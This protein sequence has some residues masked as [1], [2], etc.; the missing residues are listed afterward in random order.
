MYRYRRLVLIDRLIPFLAA[1]VGFVAL[2]AVMATQL[3]AAGRSA[4]FDAEVAATREA[5]A[6]ATAGLAAP[7]AQPAAEQGG[8]TT[9]VAALDERVARLE[10]DLADARAQ[11]ETA[12][13][14]VPAA[15]GRAL[16]AD[17]AVATDS[18]DAFDDTTPPATD[19]A[20]M[21]PASVDPS[22]PTTDCIPLGTR[23]MATPNDSYPICQSKTVIKVGTISS[24]MVD[25]AGA[26]PIPATGFANL[27]GTT[28][29]VMVFSADAEGF[30][31]MRVTCT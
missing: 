21:A 31:E 9:A 12:R 17:I 4:S 14:A 22:L 20:S 13:A 23:F 5:V 3:Q 11:I 7:A 24:D 16:P 25:V 27:P 6:A 1:G 10:A 28:C 18:T 26:G 15:T 29:T 30:A 8:E 2:L 19:A